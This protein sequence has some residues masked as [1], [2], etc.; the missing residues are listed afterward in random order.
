MIPGLGAP[1]WRVWTASTVSEL[2]TGLTNVAMPL[3]AVFYT[4][5]PR[6]VSLVAAAAFLPVVLIGLQ[7]GVIVDRPTGAGSCGRPTSHER[8]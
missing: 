6:L 2:G 4:R 5:D 7:T 3:L 1:Y 8:R